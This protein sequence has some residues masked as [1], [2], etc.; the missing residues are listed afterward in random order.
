MALDFE[1]RASTSSATPADGIVESSRK[2]RTVT[3]RAQ[4]AGGVGFA[5]AHALTVARVRS[6]SRDAGLA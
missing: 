1:S 2:S 4:S 5:A 3:R 6:A